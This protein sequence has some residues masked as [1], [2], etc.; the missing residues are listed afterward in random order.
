MMDAVAS[1]RAARREANARASAPRIHHRHYFVALA[2]G[3]CRGIGA[4][5]GVKLNSNNGSTPARR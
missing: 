5:Y 4:I 2:N 1:S 3:R